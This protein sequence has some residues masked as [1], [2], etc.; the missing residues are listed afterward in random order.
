MRDSAM[1]QPDTLSQLRQAMH[2]RYGIA[3][4]LVRVVWSPYRICPLGAHIDH[5]LGTVT[6]MA[7]DRG[8]YLAYAPSGSDE[9][10]LSSLAYSNEITIPLA[11]VPTAPL[12]DWGDYARGAIKVLSRG[13]RLRQGMVGVTSGGLPEV[14]LSSSASVGVAYLLALEDLNQLEV[15]A[16]HNIVLDQAVENEYLGLKNGILDQSAIL[17]SRHDQLTVIN[18]H[19][20]AESAFQKGNRQHEEA[21]SP[22]P[23]DQQIHLLTSVATGLQTF[24]TRSEAPT[25][26]TDDLASRDNRG[27]RWI[28]KGQAPPFTILLA[29]SGLT[30][31][32]IATD[33][34]QRV[35]ECAAAAR[36]LLDAV[37]RTDES[38]YLGNVRPEEYAAH[39]SR[40]SG[41][42]AR[43]AQHFFTEMQ[44]VH[45]GIDA[46]RGGDWIRFGKLMTESGQSSI[47]NYECGSQPLLDL[48]NLLVHTPGIYGARFSGAGFRGCCVAL[49][50]PDAARHA[51][52]ELQA[53]YAR[54]QPQLA[55]RARFLLCQ[56]ADGARR[57]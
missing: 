54:R 38:A 25:N 52:P 56:S 5:Q 41:A 44:R 21:N 18:C 39:R 15:S 20:F 28:E 51:L 32:V 33:Y 49:A 48:Y 17:L 53:A 10:R 36:I 50:E 55:A 3:P 19:A 34:N 31:A 2:D 14:G 23:S 6:A 11:H 16:A 45:D 4:A 7:I 27:I 9:V 30:Q 26:E 43:R 12:G 29:V 8:T 24:K 42:P 35:A 1:D 47:D 46:W 22:T 57:L 37:G 13:N 40:L